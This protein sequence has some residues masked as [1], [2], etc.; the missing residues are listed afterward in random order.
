MQKQGRAGTQKIR[1]QSSIYPTTSDR[2]LTPQEGDTGTIEMFP[3]NVTVITKKK[4]R[5]KNDL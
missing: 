5:K 2:L 3:I 4:L 1:S